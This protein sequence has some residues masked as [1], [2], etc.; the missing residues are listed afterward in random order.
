MSKTQK[1]IISKKIK[2]NKRLTERVAQD[3]CLT[4]NLSFRSLSNKLKHHILSW[5]NSYLNCFLRP[6][7]K[8]S[9]LCFTTSAASSLLFLPPP[10]IFSRTNKLSI[11]ESFSKQITLPPG[12]RQ[13]VKLYLW[14][15]SYAE[16]FSYWWPEEPPWET[17]DN[18]VHRFANFYVVN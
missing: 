1:A 10:G 14:N 7:A 6:K 3:D 12:I 4:F 5:I 11:S 13:E 18:R 2:I 8:T 9:T 16:I 17:S 15:N